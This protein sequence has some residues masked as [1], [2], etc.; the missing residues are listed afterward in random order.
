MTAHP[1]R[2]PVTYM[3]AREFQAEGYLQE[4]NRQFLHPLGLAL[5]IRGSKRRWWEWLLRRPRRW[6]I[7]G[8]WDFRYD[9]EGM[10]F[11]DMDNP[12]RVAKKR[13]IDALWEAREPARVEA[14]GYMIQ[15]VDV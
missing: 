15:P 7:G 9:P 1:H 5:E 6:Q 2:D 14:M 11:G 10:N 4:L 13:A 12:E 3:D 8:V